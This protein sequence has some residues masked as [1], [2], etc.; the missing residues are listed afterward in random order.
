M[1]P[2]DCLT[3]VVG[4]IE[5]REQL[6]DFNPEE[7]E[8]DF[9]TLKPITLRELEAY[10]KACLEKRALKKPAEPVE[11]KREPKK[12][13]DVRKPSAEIAARPVV[14]AASKAAN[15]GSITTNH[16]Q[17]APAAARGD[18]SSSSDSSS[19]SES[20]SSESSSDSSDSDTG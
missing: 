2:A 15:G 17:A 1:L 11:V 3:K 18:N 12:E 10:V 8:I 20:S 9:E 19:G 7:I 14:P 6:K 4:I 13:P 5:S 16:G